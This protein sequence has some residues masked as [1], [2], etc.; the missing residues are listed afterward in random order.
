M[1]QVG[2]GLREAV[3]EDAV[4]SLAQYHPGARFRVSI[5]QAQFILDELTG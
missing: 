2:R 1:R 4:H 3:A 5:R